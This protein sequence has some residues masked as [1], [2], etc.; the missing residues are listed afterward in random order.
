MIKW[1]WTN[2]GEPW[3]GFCLQSNRHIDVIF[4]ATF[5]KEVEAGFDEAINDPDKMTRLWWKILAEFC[6]MNLEEGTDID[7]VTEHIQEQFESDLERIGMEFDFVNCEADWDHH[8]LDKNLEQDRTPHDA[9]TGKCWEVA[10]HFHQDS[11]GGEHID[12]VLVSDDFDGS[13]AIIRYSWSFVSLEESPEKITVLFRGSPIQ[14]KHI[15]ESVLRGKKEILQDVSDGTVPSTVECF[16]DLGDHTD[17]AMYGGRGDD[18]WFAD[19]GQ[20]CVDAGVMGSDADPSDA[21]DPAQCKDGIHD[22]VYG[23]GI[24]ADAA[25]ALETAISVWIESGGIEG[26]AK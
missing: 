20:S 15:V 24:Q 18:G 22:S 13:P 26:G 9:W 11:G 25:N 5:I 14:I 21:C 7:K 1:D 12:S 19:L 3:Q 8:W 16:E 23:W 17:H 6:L 10:Y 2:R 4:C